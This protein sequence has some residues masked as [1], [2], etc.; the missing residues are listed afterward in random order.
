[1]VY[2][3]VQIPLLV[4]LGI[5][6]YT[7]LKWRIIPNKLI[8]LG[9][10]YFLLLRLFYTQHPYTSYLIGILVAAGPLYIMA[11]VKK[12]AFGGGDIK[13]MAVVGAAL[14]WHLAFASLVLMLTGAGIYACISYFIKRT[15]KDTI[16]LA[17]FMLLSNI[18][19]LCV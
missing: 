19:L 9:L 7:D 18:L 6:T 3:F 14:G 2:L 15:R 11:L 17:P 4:V 12:G 10:T 16:P 13:V 8:G 5:A 1:M